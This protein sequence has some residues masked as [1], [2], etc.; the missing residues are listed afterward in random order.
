MTSDYSLS[1]MVLGGALYVLSLMFLNFF[2][3]LERRLF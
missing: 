1:L 2:G 3:G